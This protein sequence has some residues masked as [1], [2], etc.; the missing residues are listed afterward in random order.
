M[1]DYYIGLLSGTS[2][3]SVDAAIVEIDPDGCRVADTH[4]HPF[5]SDLRT[6]LIEVAQSETVPVNAIAQLDAQ[7]GNLFSDAVLQL[8]ASTQIPK[9]SIRAIGSHGQTIRHHPDLDPSFTWQIGDPARIAER[10]GITTVADF[11]RRDVAAGGEGAPLA[12]LFHRAQFADREETR[13]VV[14]IGGIANVSILPADA[15]EP[16]TGFDCGP[17]NLLMDAW[18][19]RHRSE[20]FDH[21]GAWAASGKVSEPLLTRLLD[22]DFFRRTPPKS[23]GRE[24]FT[25]NWLESHLSAVSPVAPEDVQATLLELTA[26]SISAAVTKTAPDCR[27][28]LICGGGARNRALMGRLCELIAA[29]VQTT[30]A[31]GIAPEW[32]EAATF[33]WLA[34]RALIGQPSDTPPITGARHP[35]ILGAIYPA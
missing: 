17:G 27:R 4:T 15:T 20:T 6:R 10:T 9:A 8:L 26:A 13:A 34:R 11:R 12:P 29:P 22:T 1:A 31:F 16:P 32:V 3:D 21:D 28:V 14:N 24:L 19:A 2:V 35:V 7:L 18:I 25:L 23:T 33:A 30:E 5:P